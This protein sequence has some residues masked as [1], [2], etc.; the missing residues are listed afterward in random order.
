MRDVRAA[1]LLFAI[2]G[3]GRIAFD[4]R[5]TDAAVDVLDASTEIRGPG[6]W[7]PIPAA[8]L[9][10]TVWTRAV[11]SGRELV[12]FGLSLIHI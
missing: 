12:V 9:P 8:P 6:I 1:V 5:G 11:W 10:P 7:T 4:N 2:G 3:C